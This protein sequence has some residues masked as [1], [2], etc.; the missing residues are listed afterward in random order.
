MHPAKTEPTATAAIVP[1]IFNVPA[2]AAWCPTHCCLALANLD[3]IEYKR[4]KGEGSF[5]LAF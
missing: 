4:K 5:T 2:C 3:A 1:A